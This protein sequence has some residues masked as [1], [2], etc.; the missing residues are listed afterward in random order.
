MNIIEVVIL[1]IIEGLTEFLPI[2]ST[3]HLILTAKILNIPQT[4]F[5]K[6]LEIFIQLGAIIAVIIIYGS[7][8][9]KNKEMIL[10]ITT[11]FLPTALIGLL[12]YRY[13]KD[14]LLGNSL[15]T[16]AALFSG[17]IIL[18]VLE[19]FRKKTSPLI[20]GV[21][22]ISYK[23]AIMIGV[24]QSMSVVPGVSRAAA[25]IIG[26]IMTGLSRKTS[27]EFSFI[28]AIPTMIAAAL[29]DLYKERFQ[30]NGAEIRLLL[31]GI[32]LS[33]IWAIIGIKFL[34]KFTEKYS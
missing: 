18:I 19:K 12:L 4:S 5:V 11:A 34:L 17:G 31:I 27:V 24:F 3:G 20:K 30:F 6:S 25:T 33:F 15:I 7:T 29:F 32:I 21:E 26:G 22:M 16:V 9:W 1:S 2:S 13:I 23:S 10:K 14:V 8:I 28:L